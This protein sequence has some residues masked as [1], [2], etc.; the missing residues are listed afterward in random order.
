M[1]ECNYK[2]NSKIFMHVVQ[3]LLWKINLKYLSE[4]KT[5]DKI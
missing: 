2:N 4:K 3:R 5:V 1:N